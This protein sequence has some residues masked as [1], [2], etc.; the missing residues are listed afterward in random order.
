MSY[1]LKIYEITM[2]NLICAYVK[3]DYRASKPLCH[4]LALARASILVDMYFATFS[5]TCLEEFSYYRTSIEG[6]A[7]HII[8]ILREAR[9]IQ[10][11]SL[12][13]GIY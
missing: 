1:K 4:R 8:L 10:S 2:R 3:I 9:S 6:C 7:D 13:E 5:K 11:L 12:A